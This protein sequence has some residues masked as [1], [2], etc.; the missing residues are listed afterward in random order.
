MNE[1]DP[2][3]TGWKLDAKYPDG[4]HWELT[5]RLDAG[6]VLEAVFANFPA[7]CS[8][9]M[10]EAWL[11]PGITAM[12]EALATTSEPSNTCWNAVRYAIP[13]GREMP[14]ELKQLV[15]SHAGPE[16][17]ANAFVARGNGMLLVWFDFPD[18]PIAIHP[19]VGE[20]FVRRLA[21]ETGLELRRRS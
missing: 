17:C 5:G 13:L 7:G 19:D 10:E 16:Y 9:V 21:K 3:A 2:N 6:R 8:L 4:P 12:L 18:E 20:A 15:A 1:P 14:P 11:T